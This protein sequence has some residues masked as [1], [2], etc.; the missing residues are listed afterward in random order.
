MKWY[1]T[2]LIFIVSIFMFS[3]W[4][5]YIPSEEEIEFEAICD[6]YPDLGT[7]GTEF[8]FN[9]DA[10]KIK[11][12]SIIDL[13]R[14][15]FR[16]DFDN[17]GT[18]DT[19]WVDNVERRHTFITEGDNKIIIEVKTPGLD[20]Y[21][22]TCN[23]LVQPLI[24]IYDN[25]SGYD[26]GHVDWS[27]DGSNRIAFDGPLNIVESEIWTA[28]YPNTNLKQISSKNAS[29]PEWSSDGKNILFRR[30]QEF[31]VVNLETGKELPLIV[32][33][34]VI[35][36]VP[37]WSHNIRKLAY[38]TRTSIEIYN[39]NSG[40]VT[41]IPTDVTYNLISWSPDD[42]ILA[43]ASR[44]NELSTIDFF[45]IEEDKLSTSITLGF[46]YTGAKLDWS[47]NNKWLSIGFA[48][49]SNVLYLFNRYSG[50]FKQI[51]INGLENVWY[52]S[53]SYDSEMLVFEGRAQG[54]NTSIWGIQ[55]P[56]DF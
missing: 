8:I 26:I 19:K 48:N 43:V 32:W 55:I 47:L 12:D 52:A 50:E 5:F 20:I 9:I 42:Q 16:W 23:V 24:K 29:F 14:Y 27:G 56:D 51:Q 49:S 30:G 38:T 11:R 36:F 1:K 31:W 21:R 13:A 7:P 37:S 35:P 53:W 40:S 45:D 4:G 39:I 28:D 18:F 54:E 2:G 41:R 3:C 34:G 33:G 25:I 15:Q 10:I 44:N 17:D 22:D 6:I 46:N